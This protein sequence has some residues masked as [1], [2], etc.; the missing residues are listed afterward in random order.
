M[1]LAELHGTVH[2]RTQE[3]VSA[4]ETLKMKIQSRTNTEEAS[5]DSEKRFHQAF[6]TAPVPLVILHANQQRITDANES[7][8]RL[9]GL[10]KAELH[11]RTVQETC[12]LEGATTW[13]DLVPRLASGEQVSSLNLAIHR[14]DGESRHTVAWFEPLAP[15]TQPQLLATLV[16]LTAQHRLEV[17]LR[18]SHKMEAVGQLAAGVAHDFNS[19]LSVIHGHV[20]MQLAR[21]DLDRSVASSLK[22]VKQAAE[23]AATLTRQLLTF[24]RKQVVHCTRFDLNATVARQLELLQRAVGETVGIEW[25]PAPAPAVVDAD[26]PSLEQVVM[27]LLLNARDAMPNGGHLAVSVA[28]A[29]LTGSPGHHPDAHAGPYVVLTTRDAGCGIDARILSRIFEPFFTT[30]PPGKGTGLGLAIV[31]AIVH[32]HGG[33]VEVDST[34]GQGSTFRVFLPAAKESLEPPAR[35]AASFPH[36]KRQAHGETVL[37]AEDEPALRELVCLTLATHGY[38]V[39][40]AGCGVEAMAVWQ[41]APKRVDLLLTDMVMPNGVSGSQ[42]ASRL[43]QRDRELKVVYTSGY[44][45]EVIANGGQLEEGL[46]FLSKPFTVERLLG[47]VGRALDATDQAVRLVEPNWP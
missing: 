21:P 38:N 36:R 17:Q 39:L 45:P 24:S 23:R 14:H 19:L 15:G 22:Q 42:L 26:E 41:S 47:V 35:P 31:Y 5:Q 3:L 7:F 34:L 16:D 37:V 32:R 6:E 33:W 28:L 1:R 27:N 29:D 20:S 9:V 30:K 13:D 40:S 4:N 43:L 44:S 46:N 2:V 12:C 11:G 18:E 10:P 25:H 8:A